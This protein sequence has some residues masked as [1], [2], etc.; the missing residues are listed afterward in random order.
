[1]EHL[2]GHTARNRLTKVFDWQ[3]A[4]NA[5]WFAVKDSLFAIWDSLAAYDDMEFPSCAIRYARIEKTPKRKAAI[6]PHIWRTVFQMNCVL[7]GRSST[8]FKL[9]GLGTSLLEGNLGSRNELD[10]S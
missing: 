10:S 5:N 2:N 3:Y 9:I 7:M 8:S 1:L 6:R 4:S